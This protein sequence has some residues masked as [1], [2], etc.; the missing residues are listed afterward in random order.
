MEEKHITLS[1][2]MSNALIKDPKRLAFVLSRYTFAG[3][4]TEDCASILELGCSEGIGAALLHKFEKKY[5]GLD[6]DSVAIEAAKKNFWAP[7][8]NFELAN[9]LHP[10]EGKYGGVVSLDVLEH[11]SPGNNEKLYFETITDHLTDHGVC[12]IGTPNITSSQYASTESMAGHV[13]MFSAQRLKDVMSIF[14][15]TVF[16]F[17]MNDEIVHTGYYPMAHYLFSVGCS[18]TIRYC[19]A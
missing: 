9:F 8:V 1:P 12:V 13:N 16:I 3:Q 2:H 15:N 14:F 7:C 19:R 10:F 5:L 17:S 4:M 18:K 11:I 6:L